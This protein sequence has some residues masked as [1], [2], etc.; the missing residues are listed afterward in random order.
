M[1]AFRNLEEDSLDI[2]VLGSSHAYVDINPAVL[3]SEYGIAAYDLCG[4][5]QPMWN[6]Y[7]YLKEALKTQTPKVVV[8]EAYCVSLDLEYIDEVTLYKALEGRTDM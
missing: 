6:T 8:L 5:N 1:D 2:L 4:S 3:W 7:Y